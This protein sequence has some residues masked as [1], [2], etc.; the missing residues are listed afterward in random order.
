MKMLEKQIYRLDRKE[1]KLLNK[2]AGPI[3]RKIRP[4]ISKIKDKIPEK[5]QDHIRRIF[6]KAF[7]M[8]FEKGTSIIEKTYRKEEIE[9]RFIANNY[10]YDQVKSRRSL[11]A[12]D[13]QSKRF[14]KTGTRIAF[15]EGAGLGILGIGIPDIPIFT[16][17]LLKGIYEIA[18]SY[19][20]DYKNYE[21]KLYILKL[22]QLSLDSAGEKEISSHALDVFAKE[23][24]HGIWQGSLDQEIKKTADLLSE[25]LFVA[26]FIQGLPLVGVAGALFNYRI[27]KKITLMASFKYKK[28]YLML[29]Q[30]KKTSM[31]VL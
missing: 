14:R 3:Q 12:L 11:R 20:F 2:K 29:K 28:R 9:A 8:I 24:E 5:V 4:V 25:E 18:L 13:D 31:E 16:A 17:L 15:I 7:Y 6:E 19:G 27:Y 23:I 22:I 21:E 30:I 1:A 10:I 26:K